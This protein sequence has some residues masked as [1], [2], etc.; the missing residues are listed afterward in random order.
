MEFSYLYGSLKNLSAFKEFVV[1]CYYNPF[2]PHT[3]L[4]I[5][6]LIMIL[7]YLI[8]AFYVAEEMHLMKV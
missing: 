3:V 4:A 1:L 2:F 6:M 5:F 7:K 8:Y